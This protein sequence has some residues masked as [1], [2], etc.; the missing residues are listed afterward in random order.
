M[1]FAG[2]NVS[3]VISRRTEWEMNE[4]EYHSTTVS[5]FPVQVSIFSCFMFELFSLC[6]FSFD[7]NT[8]LKS[9]VTTMEGTIA[10][11]LGQK[12]K[13][14]QP[15]LSSKLPGCYKRKIYRFSDS[16]IL[17]P[18]KV[19]CRVFKYIGFSAFL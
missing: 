5:R 15:S 9:D 14:E 2:T 8:R 1:S 17:G 13:Y 3:D 12:K 4:W 16:R 18:H 10:Y 7:K 11:C 19:L 6:S